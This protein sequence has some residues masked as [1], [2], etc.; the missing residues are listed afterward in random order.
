[1]ERNARLILVSSFLLFT[2]IT[3]IL[4]Y[5]WIQQPEATDAD[6]SRLV[7]F[8]SSVSGLSIGSEVRYLGVPVGRVTA[9]RL[10]PDYRGRVDVT[11]ASDQ[12]LPPSNELVALLEAQGIT[13][14]SII[15]LQDR[16]SDLDTF[17]HNAATIPGRP[18]V[19]GQLSGSA[20]RISDS[21]EQTLQRIND[22]LDADSMADLDATLRHTRELSENLATAS[23]QFDEVLSNANN[24]SEEL[25]RTLPD[26]RAV[27]QRLD[28]EVLP[29]LTS[30][31]ES[32]QTVGDAA[33]GVINDNRAEIDQLI[34]RE[35]PTLIGVTDELADT[36]QEIN[37]LVGNI[38]GQPG[39]LLYG[40]QVKE[41][42]ISRE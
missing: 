19:L 14:L 16:P 18:S 36:L 26:F 9:I 10:S 38:N 22:M 1:M 23:Q 31:G 6:D 7:Q 37:R 28:R 21:V 11:I 34:N 33:A 40:E 20:G 12:A 24:I 25:A 5:R 32:L 30:A 13:G 2:L 15:E 42:E 8:N 29:A 27:A 41:V 35:L 3:I 4:F 17:E 39:A